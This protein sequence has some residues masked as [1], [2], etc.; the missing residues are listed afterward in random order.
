MAGAEAEEPATLAER[1]E[2][3]LEEE[4]ILTEIADLGAEGAEGA[5]DLDAAITAERER[6]KRAKKAEAKE[7]KAE[8]SLP[9]PLPSLPPPGLGAEG[10]ATVRAEEVPPKGPVGTGT[11]TTWSP[12]SPL[13]ELPTPPPSMGTPT[14]TPLPAST[15]PRGLQKHRS[16]L[17]LDPVVQHEGQWDVLK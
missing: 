7:S 5:S 4:D 16:T 17:T 10:A 2:M 11:G 1:E 15:A 14:P 13:E 6:A 12:R 3:L 9:P 8:L